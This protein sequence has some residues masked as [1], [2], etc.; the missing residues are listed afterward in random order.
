MSLG[1]ANELASSGRLLEAEE[2]YWTEIERGNDAA[3]LSLAYAFHD[4]G[5][6]SL[7]LEHYGAL[8]GTP[9]WEAAAPQVSDILLDVHKYE[10][11]RDALQGLSGEIVDSSIR[12]IESVATK[13]AGYIN[14]VPG[15]VESA[16]FEEQNLLL[17]I[18]ANPNLPAQIQLTETR[19]YLAH[20]ATV[21][22]S[23]IGKKVSNQAIEIGVGPTLSRSLSN[24]IGTP[25]RRWFD[26][27]HAAVNAFTLL[28][29]QN[30]GMSQDFEEIALSA[31]TFIEK[32]YV[33][34]GRASSEND[35]DFVI[36]NLIWALNQLGHPAKDFY[37]HLLLA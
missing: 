1:K 3:R 27:A 31:M 10:E 20:Y 22:S 32:K 15:I 36:N 14:D 17:L 37:A 26:A 25:S 9:H 21:L 19:K 28:M 33:I 7:A 35:E 24:A 8:R 30:S 12:A 13:T 23:S 18:D 5:L 16:L 11:A 34:S 6:L 2:I 4:A 29:Q